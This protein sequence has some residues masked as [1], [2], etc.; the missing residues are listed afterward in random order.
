M[1]L[2]SGDQ[3]IGEPSFSYEC[4]YTTLAEMQGCI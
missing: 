2:I 3:E 1:M 4:S